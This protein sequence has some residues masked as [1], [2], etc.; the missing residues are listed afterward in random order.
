MVFLDMK[1]NPVAQQ[2]LVMRLCNFAPIEIPCFR[3]LI[4]SQDKHGISGCETVSCCSTEI[5][6]ETV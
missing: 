5:N 1:R 2:G 3:D 6:N 4:K